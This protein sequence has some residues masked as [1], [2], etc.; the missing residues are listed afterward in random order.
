MKAEE[1]TPTRIAALGRSVSTICRE[2]APNC[3]IKNY[4][5]SLAIKR[6]DQPRPEAKKMQT[7]DPAIGRR[8][9]NPLAEHLCPEQI[10]A[11]WKLELGVKLGPET[12]YPYI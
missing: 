10:S 9:R 6:I 4:R 1:S 3:D 12:I 2:L 11:G 8:I 5:S 7:L